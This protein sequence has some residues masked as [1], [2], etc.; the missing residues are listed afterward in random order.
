MMRSFLVMAIVLLPCA[1]GAATGPGNGK[2]VDYSTAGRELNIA[3]VMWAAGFMSGRMVDAGVYSFSLPTD[4]LRD[5]LTAYCR[6]RPN[7]QFVIAVASVHRYL[8]T[9]K[10]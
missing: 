1:A 10:W 5:A 6:E 3:Y 4:Q 8:M 9:G 7:L 2:C